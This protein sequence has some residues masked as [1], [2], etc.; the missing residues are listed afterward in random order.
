[1]SAYDDGD[2]H[3]LARGAPE[4]VMP[5]AT[6]VSEPA[7]DRTI[8]GENLHAI[9]T[10]IVLVRAGR[11]WFACE[12]QRPSDQRSGLARPTRLYR[13][14]LKINAVPSRHHTRLSRH[15]LGAHCEGSPSEGNLV[16]GL[17]E[18]LRRARF[19]KLRQELTELAQILRANAKSPGRS[20]DCPKHIHEDGDV[21]C[22][23]IRQNWSL[24]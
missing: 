24:E 10:D 13:Q 1:M 15:V 20:L 23:P 12:N 7:N 11:A 3:F 8:P 5:R 21:R 22:A 16:P 17:R 9:D 4:R 18:C 19:P 6:P 14:A 2:G